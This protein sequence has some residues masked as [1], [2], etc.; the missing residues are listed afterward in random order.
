AR[1]RGKGRAQVTLQS[2][3]GAVLTTD[4]TG[5]V[6]YLSPAAEQL[7]G[8]DRR[9]AQGKRVEDVVELLDEEKGTPVEPP[10]VRCLAEG[11]TITLSADVA[12]K[13]RDGTAIAIQQSAAPIQDRGGRVIE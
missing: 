1:F 3:G 7:T 8:W 4:A 10:V 9:D 6:E 2:I 5:R 13:H 11:R 12:L